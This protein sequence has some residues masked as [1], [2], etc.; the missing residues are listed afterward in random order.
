[1][2]LSETMEI[3]SK[4]RATIFRLLK[5]SDL[6]QVSVARMR[7]V[8]ITLESIERYQKRSPQEALKMLEPDSLRAERQVH[9]KKR[10]PEVFK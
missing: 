5:K 3:L 10:F 2:D 9:L 4:S 6:I 7:T 1:M 8:Y